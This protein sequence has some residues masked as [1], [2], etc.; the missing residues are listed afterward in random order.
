MRRQRRYPWGGPA[1]RWKPYPWGGRTRGRLLF[2]LALPVLLLA[3]TGLLIVLLAPLDTDGDD[4]ELTQPELAATATALAAEHAGN[5]RPAELPPGVFEH[6]HPE[7]LPT[8][9]V[10]NV[11]DGDTIEVRIEGEPET[12]RYYGIDT[13]ERG[14][15]CYEEAKKRNEEL[16]DRHVLLMADARDRDRGGRLLRY[17]FTLDGHSV[18]AALVAEGFAHAWTLDGYYRDTI[19]ALEKEAQREGRGCLWGEGIEGE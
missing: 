18:D 17:V 7:S 13:P 16:V 5:D 10:M 9:I 6:P 2:T 4:S 12:V 15:P 8:A 19:V 1:R 3:L 14:E 11:I